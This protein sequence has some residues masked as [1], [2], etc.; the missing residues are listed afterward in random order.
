MID[1]TRAIIVLMPTTD[2]TVVEE[3]PLVIMSRAL[4]ETL[5]IAQA[6]GQLMGLLKQE[7]DRAPMALK[8]AVRALSDAFTVSPEEV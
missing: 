8:D 4:I 3:T 2:D 5:A 7:Y 1:M 6:D